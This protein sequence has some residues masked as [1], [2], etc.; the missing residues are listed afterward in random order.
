MT[1]KFLYLKNTLIR[2]NPKI[3]PA[4][5]NIMCGVKNESKKIP[6]IKERQKYRKIFEAVITS[7]YLTWQTS[8]N[9]EM[10]F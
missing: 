3:N 10:A 8:K 7:F 1:T 6:P 4:H 9:G 5:N 2:I